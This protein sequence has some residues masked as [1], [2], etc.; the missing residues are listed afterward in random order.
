VNSALV[1]AIS[2]KRLIEFVYKGGRPRIAEPH[3]YGI[4][5]GVEGLLAYQ[6]SGESRSGNP[7]G[8]KNFELKNMRQ[9]RVLDR[10]FPGSRADSDQYHDT[11]DTLFVPSVDSQ[12]PQLID[13]SN[14][15][16]S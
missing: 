11:W 13:T 12:I 15:A 3:D 16:I 2:G 9:L 5:K 1:I 4:R 7:H 14:P 10:Q 8:W 6:I